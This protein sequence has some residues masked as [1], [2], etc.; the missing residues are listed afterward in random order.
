MVR[1]S[2]G[3]LRIRRMRVAAD[4]PRG[5]ATRRNPD[6]SLPNRWNHRQKKKVKKV[7]KKLGNS[8]HRGAGRYLYWAPRLRGSGAR[9]AWRTP[10]PAAWDEP[11]YWAPAPWEVRLDA[12]KSPPDACLFA[13]GT[14]GVDWFASGGS[15]CIQGDQSRWMKIWT[16][17]KVELRGNQASVKDLGRN[18][19]YRP[20]N[21]LG[22]ETRNRKGK[23]GGWMVRYQPRSIAPAPLTLIRSG[24]IRIESIGKMQHQLRDRRG[25]GGAQ[26]HCVDGQQNTDNRQGGVEC[27][28]Q[29]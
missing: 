8:L 7:G 27:R 14:D 20:F 3:L 21:D 26:P 29:I 1:R 23:S 9:F 11:R 6:Q 28:E 10:T 25:G 17:K 4:R 22:K 19:E 18:T 16:D 13:W 12:V 15:S 24:L 5:T 2:C